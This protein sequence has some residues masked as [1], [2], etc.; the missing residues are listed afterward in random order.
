MDDCL[1]KRE[2]IEEIGDVDYE[3]Q[4]LEHNIQMQ[5]DTANNVQGPEKEQLK[6]N[7]VIQKL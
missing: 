6:Q 4:K 2:V 1:N 3:I 5:S 7:I